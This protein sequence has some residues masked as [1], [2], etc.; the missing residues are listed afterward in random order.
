MCIFSFV[1]VLLNAL[2]SINMGHTRQSL[3]LHFVG[4]SGI[5]YLLSDGCKP[6]FFISV[7]SGDLVIIFFKFGKIL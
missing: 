6:V 1:V 5:E 3:L 7:S 2:A 4:S